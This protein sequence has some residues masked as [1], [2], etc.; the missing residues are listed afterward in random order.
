MNSTSQLEADLLHAQHP[1]CDFKVSIRMINSLQQSFIADMWRDPAWLDTE[2]CRELMREDDDDAHV[3]RNHV[4]NSLEV[5]AAS[6][7]DDKRNQQQG[8][9]RVMEYGHHQLSA[10]NAQLYGEVTKPC[11]ALISSGIKYKYFQHI[12]SITEEENLS[13]LFK[14]VYRPDK[15]VLNERMMHVLERNA[16]HPFLSYDVCMFSVTGYAANVCHP[17]VSIAQ[18]QCMFVTERYHKHVSHLLTRDSRSTCGVHLAIPVKPSIQPLPDPRTMTKEADEITTTG[19]MP[20]SSIPNTGQELPDALQLITKYKKLM[21]VIS[22]NINDIKTVNQM[23][24]EPGDL[25]V[26]VYGYSYFQIEG[27]RPPL[28]S[29]RRSVGRTKSK[30]RCTLL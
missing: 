22:R 3:I 15:T 23:W 8:V 9:S 4:T 14:G 25:N 17:L 21:R 27:A 13:E 29:E 11:V 30:S 19:R 18:E 7:V 28:F 1:R 16:K 20:P 2:L 26:E 24:K 6:S 10:E 12:R 5:Y